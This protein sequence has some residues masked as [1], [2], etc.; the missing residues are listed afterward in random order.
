[1]IPV[2]ILA[3]NTRHIRIQSPTLSSSSSIMIDHT[4]G[5]KL[6]P[7]LVGCYCLFLSCSAFLGW[8]KLNL[9]STMS[10]CLWLLKMQC[11]TIVDSSHSNHSIFVNPCIRLGDNEKMFVAKLIYSGE[12]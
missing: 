12:K 6:C 5:N 4:T 11:H 10:M 3:T 7:N 8:Q 9:L 1:M 2:L